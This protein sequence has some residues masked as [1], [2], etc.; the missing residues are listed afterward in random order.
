[1]GQGPRRKSKNKKIIYLIC[2]R[3][4]KLRMSTNQTTS[5]KS[6]MKLRL[7][8][9][10]VKEVK[11]EVASEEEEAAVEAEEV[12]QEEVLEEEVT[13]RSGASFEW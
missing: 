12:T 6:L 10:T 2:K 13:I 1:M 9:L 3:T 7:L 4:L 11:A 5:P 8:E